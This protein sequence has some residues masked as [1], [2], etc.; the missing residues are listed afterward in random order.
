MEQLTFEAIKPVRK[1]LEHPLFDMLRPHIVAAFWEYHEANP[2]V[3]GIYLNFSREAKK[4]GRKRYGVQSIAERVRWY[5]DIE[6]NSTDEFKI[7]NNHQSCYARL[8]AILY[9]QEFEHF[10]Q[11]RHTPG[12]TSN[13]SE[14]DQ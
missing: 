2:H 3:F 8:L 9:P 14:Y 5:V 10:F 13:F 4:T 11:F 12:S 6:T 7:N 1:N